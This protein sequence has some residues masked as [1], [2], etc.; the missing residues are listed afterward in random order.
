[1]GCGKRVLGPDGFLDA[2]SASARVILLVGSG[3]LLSVALPG[4]PAE[5][6]GQP[7]DGQDSG[8]PQGPIAPGASQGRH[9]GRGQ[10]QPDEEPGDAPAANLPKPSIE[11]RQRLDAG[12]VLCGTE[13]QLRRH[14]AAI[15]ARLAGQQMGEP[16]GCHFVPEMVKVS[17]LSRDG[18]AATQVQI[19]GASSPV[20]GWTDSMVHDQPPAYGQ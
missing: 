15:K 20:N 9:R 13:D 1:M 16:V 8:A 12:A 14:Q 4:L 7:A 6:W 3:L 11:P 18:A 17:V 19:P 2:M 5:A 10:H